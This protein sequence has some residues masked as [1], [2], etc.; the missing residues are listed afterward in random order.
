MCTVPGGLARVK[1]QFEKDQ[2]ASSRHTFSQYQHQ[3]QNRSEQVTLLQLMDKS[4]MIEMFPFQ[5]RCG[6]CCYHQP[7]PLYWCIYFNTS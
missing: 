3:L 2:V 4:G 1:K 7:P 6:H 5:C